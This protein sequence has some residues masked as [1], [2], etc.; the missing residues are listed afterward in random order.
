[1][2]GAVWGDVGLVTFALE[3]SYTMDGQKQTR[4]APTSIV[5][6]RQDGDWRIEL[7]HSVPLPEQA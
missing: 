5:F 2:A 1:V 7:I 6:R 3:Q 4:E